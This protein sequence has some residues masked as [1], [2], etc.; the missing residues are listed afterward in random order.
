MRNLARH[1]DLLLRS[2]DCVILPGFGGFIAQS[3]PAYYVEEEHLFYPPSRSIS[4][5]AAITMNDGLLA[6]S[7]M[8]SYQVDYARATYM[9]DVAIDNMRDILDEE[10]EVTLPYIGTIK[11]D[12]HQTLQFTSEQATLT[13][14]KHFGLDAF[15][16]KELSKLQQGDSAYAHHAKPL[17]T[18]TEKTIDVHIRKEVLRQVLSTAAVML[19]LLMVSLPIGHHKPTDIASLQLPK[20]TISQ[21]QSEEPATEKDMTNDT[22]LATDTMATFVAENIIGTSTEEHAQQAFT[23]PIASPEATPVI[24]NVVEQTIANTEATQQDT[25]SVSEPV[26]ETPQVVP[27]KIY[28]IIVASLPSHRGAE[29]TLNK[30]IEKGHTHVSLVERDDRVRISLMQFTDKDEANSYLKELRTQAGFENAWLLAVRN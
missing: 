30:Y 3:V 9:I 26:A 20:M 7:Y 5:N 16:I 8:K 19:L 29:E 4:F 28:H 21:W 12:I 11:Q 2:N 22:V 6:Q 17:I 15:L 1:I 23:E 13:S 25:P 10:G 18:K 24:E 14:P 27:S